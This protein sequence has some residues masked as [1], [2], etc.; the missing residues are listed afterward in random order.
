MP[1]QAFDYVSPENLTIILNI[2]RY[3]SFGVCKVLS[4][5]MFGTQIHPKQT[6]PKKKIVNIV[7]RKTMKL[8]ES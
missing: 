2:V 3:R 7:N 8:T 6:Q 1:S 5:I 4:N